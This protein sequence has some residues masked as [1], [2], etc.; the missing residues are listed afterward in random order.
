[1]KLREVKKL[2]QAYAASFMVLKI[3]G[4]INDSKCLENS[5]PHTPLKTSWKESKEIT[6]VMWYTVNIL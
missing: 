5:H 2:D 4:K 3:L 1:M 6:K